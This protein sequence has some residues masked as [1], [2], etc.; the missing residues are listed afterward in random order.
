MY[1]YIN[2]LVFTIQRS[3]TAL[4]DFEQSTNVCSRV[5]NRIDM[6]LEEAQNA[7]LTEMMEEVKM[8]LHKFVDESEEASSY[9]VTRKA[10]EL[11]L[12]IA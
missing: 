10:C 6:M 12:S 9:K 3:Y 4:Y 7:E 2:E 11:L 1:S 5:C 8:M